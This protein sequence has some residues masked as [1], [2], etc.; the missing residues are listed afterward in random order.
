MLS[1]LVHMDMH[2][3]GNEEISSIISEQLY[4]HHHHQQWPYTKKYTLLLSIPLFFHV[5]VLLLEPLCQSH[6]KEDCAPYYY[7]YPIKVPRKIVLPTTAIPCRFGDVTW[8][9]ML[10]AHQ[11]TIS[12]C[13]KKWRSLWWGNKKSR[14][15]SFL[16]EETS[17]RQHTVC[18]VPGLY[19]HH[20]I[21][22]HSISSIML[23]GLRTK[24]Y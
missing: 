5:L 24:T 13:R 7:C 16:Q 20:I 14:W 19:I 9:G 2:T 10:K 21:S 8:D 11:Q 18:S 23:H 4:H 6:V 22:Y 15:G 17:K 12:L 1:V 3:T